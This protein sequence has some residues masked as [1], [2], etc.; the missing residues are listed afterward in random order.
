MCSKENLI[1]ALLIPLFH[2]ERNE[3]P[4]AL[5]YKNKGGGEVYA[6]KCLRGH[7]FFL[8][9]ALKGEIIHRISPPIICVACTVKMGALKFF[10]VHA[11]HVLLHLNRDQ[12]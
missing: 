12:T 6:L 2:I 3:L 4:V 8:C 11:K 1:L 5:M 10:Q 7:F 9:L